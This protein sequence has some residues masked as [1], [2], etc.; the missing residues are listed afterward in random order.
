MLNLKELIFG[1]QTGRFATPFSREEAARRLAASVK[2]TVLHTLFRQAVVGK[3]SV[4]RVYLYRYRPFI[5]NSF[6]PVF[7]GSFQVRDGV[8]LLEGYFSMHWYTKAFLI[9]WYGLLAF[10]PIVAAIDMA[11]SGL[12]GKELV[13]EALFVI[14]LVLFPIGLT[15]FGKWYARDDPRYISEVIRK[16]IGADGA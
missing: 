5:Q 16:A 10:F 11:R 8:T 9:L 3:V 7:L 12:S 2:R 14:V 1:S 15:M 6:A 13:R 4:E